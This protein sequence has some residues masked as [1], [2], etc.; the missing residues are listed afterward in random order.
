MFLVRFV[1]SVALNMKANSKH[2]IYVIK[3]GTDKMKNYSV[4]YVLRLRSMA[5]NFMYKILISIDATD[6]YKINSYTF[7]DKVY[8]NM[9]RNRTDYGLWCQRKTGKIK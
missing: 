4:S 6:D 9:F 2:I 1:R 8:V 5:F 7:V 3:N